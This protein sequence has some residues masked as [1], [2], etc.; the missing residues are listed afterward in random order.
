MVI[1]LGCG[2]VP[3]KP[4]MKSAPS[5]AL[6]DKP[7]ADLSRY[8]VTGAE[9]ET[10]D[11]VNQE[12]LKAAV[13]F[14]A[15]KMTGS[16]SEQQTVNSYIDNNVARLTF[17]RS[18]KVLR[19]TFSADGRSMRRDL[20]V[21]VKTDDLKAFLE[22]QQLVTAGGDLTSALGNPTIMV[23]HADAIADC[24][25]RNRTPKCMLEK[26]AKQQQAQIA[27]AEGSVQKLQAQIMAKGCLDQQTDT[28][29]SS[30]S[31]Y[32]RSSAS[33]ERSADSQSNSNRYD[34][35]ARSA[36]AY[37]RGA[38]TSSSYDRN[39]GRKSSSA[40]N[41][42]SSDAKAHGRR[43]SYD[44]YRNSNSKRTSSNS[45]RYK[46]DFGKSNDEQRDSASESSNQTDTASESSSNS[47]SSAGRRSQTDRASK[48]KSFSQRIRPSANCRQFI[49][50]LETRGNKVDNERA[51]L[52]R[53]QSKQMQA[54]AGAQSLETQTSIIS[55]FFQR[56]GYDLVNR[57]MM[58][59]RLDKENKLAAATQGSTDLF[60]NMARKLGADVLVTYRFD[61]ESGSAG[62]KLSAD[63]RAYS[64]IDGSEYASKNMSSKAF[65]NSG[66][67]NM[68][69]TALKDA[70]QRGMEDFMQQISRR[71][72]KMARNGVELQVVIR[73]NFTGP[74]ENVP[75]WVEEDLNALTEGLKGKFSDSLTLLPENVSESVAEF[76]ITGLKSKATLAQVNR[77]VRR[78]IKRNHPLRVVYSDKYRVEFQLK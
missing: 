30:S 16:K 4:R 2:G 59:R 75:D 73:G 29:K 8:Y 69:N 56:E 58:M 38:S 25:K 24:P 34:R 18:G 60:R 70:L 28:R 3:P 9:G 21:T 54:A 57:E 49:K 10:P 5:V 47:R 78:A 50:M 39:S 68:R 53:I 17:A 63:V 72:T 46:N 66:R 35:S 65:A 7:S 62:Y 6:K 36:N 32:D 20:F 19:N 15:G 74:F 31:S 12:A 77:S 52:A 33:S 61:P 44:G 13:K 64:T 48:Q 26:Q 11:E 1:I 55:E 14:A 51:K 27:Q 23:L 43:G 37:D 41:S 40:S 22:S 42:D 71:W 45:S 76:R 67:D